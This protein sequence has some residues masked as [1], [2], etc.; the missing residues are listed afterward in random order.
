MRPHFN[1]HTKARTVILYDGREGAIPIGG[2]LPQGGPI[3]AYQ[4]A[5]QVAKLVPFSAP[6]LHITL[7]LPPERSLTRAAWQDLIKTM[8]FHMDMRPEAMPW[9]AWKHTDTTQEHAHIVL[10]LTTFTGR[11]VPFRASEGLCN[12]LHRLHAQRLGL[13]IPAYFEEKAAVR[14]QSSI[15]KRRARERDIPADLID[16]LNSVFAECQP[17]SVHALNRALAAKPGGYE[18][19]SARSDDEHEFYEFVAPNQKTIS[20]SQLGLAWKPRFVRQRFR[21]ARLLAELRPVLELQ[22]LHRLFRDR[23]DPIFQRQQ[24]I[25]DGRVQRIR[26][27]AERAE[28]PGNPS[29]VSQGGGRAD[30]PDQEVGEAPGHGGNDP[31]R[32]AGAASLGGSAAERGPGSPRSG[33]EVGRNLGHARGSRGRDVVGHE[34]DPG[35]DLPGQQ[36]TGGPGKAT[37]DNRGA[38]ERDRGSLGASVRDVGRS[39][40]SAREFYRRMMVLVRDAAGVERRQV[41]DR[42]RRIRLTFSDGSVVAA[43]AQDVV[44]LEGGQGSLAAT[45]ALAHAEA[46]DCE[47]LP[48]LVPDGCILRRGSHVVLSL[49]GD[50]A[51]RMRGD[52]LRRLEPVVLWSGAFGPDADRLLAGLGFSAKLKEL[53]DVAP[54]RASGVVLLLTQSCIDA[55]AEADVTLP[56]LADPTPCVFFPDLTEMSWGRAKKRIAALQA[57][58]APEMD[59]DE[60]SMRE[61][62]GPGM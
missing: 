37:V 59:P 30:G 19:R 31:R 25:A 2:T 45:F 34:A 47:A 21:L 54:E 24:E 14:Q 9:A 62:D 60:R 55:L 52:A 17:Q 46:F 22:V 29:A 5:S 16:D 39:S 32:R 18:M 40:L 42:F 6:L 27:R 4:Q 11:E 41:S 58:A 33:P 1:P 49:N 44:L 3:K 50:R 26:A 10:M 43:T 28:N 36:L 61:D 57:L 15:P 38:P 56:D 35:G 53:S 8:L 48:R 12:D 51:T 7:S 20:A 23:L 13:P